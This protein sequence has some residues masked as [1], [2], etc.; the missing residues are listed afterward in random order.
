MAQLSETHTEKYKH[1]TETHEPV[2]L[3]TFQMLTIFVAIV[4]TATVSFLAGVVYDRHQSLAYSEEFEIFWEAWQYIDNEFYREPPSV[5]DR[6]Y[7][8]IRGVISTLGDEYTS[9]SPPVMAEHS[10]EVISGK[11]GGIGATVSTD[12]A[13]DSYIVE[14]ISDQCITATPAERAGLQAG[15]VFRA[16]D[17]QTVQGLE[18][19]LVVDMVRGD[20]DTDVVLTMYRPAEDLTFDVTVR[21][22]NV[23]QITVVDQMYG[24]VAYLHLGLFNAVATQQMACKLEQVL[25]QNPRAIILDLRGN[26]GGLLNEATQI[27][28]LFLDQGLIVIQRDREGNEER[29]FSETGG[30]AEQIPM[31]VLIDGGS[32]SASEVVAGALQDRGRAVL[33]GQNSFGKGSV[34]FVYILSDGG[35]LRVTA[36][37]WYTPN[38]HGINRNGDVGGLTPDILIEGDQIGEDGNDRTLEAALGYIDQHM[39]VEFEQAAQLPATTRFLGG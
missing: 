21:R 32:A 9:V 24:D 18:M 7:G 5:T 6:V 26:G 10:R 3:T 39:P 20:P 27:A 23:E 38:N 11:F 15:D 14:V 16:V 2:R 12:E 22:A 33:V 31:L 35:E 1:T 8:G 13:G 36:A 29:L 30:I 19:N 25:A 37:A 4:A 34:Q 17:G 28:D